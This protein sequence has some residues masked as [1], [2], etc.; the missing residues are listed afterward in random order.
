MKNCKAITAAFLLVILTALSAF[1]KLD[2]DV[3]KKVAEQL[4]KWV[5]DNPQEKVYL[6]FDKP[7]YAVGDDIWF[8][9]YVTAGPKH[10]LS[11]LSGILNV[12][13]ITDRD[14]IK[15]AIKIPLSAGLG[16]GDFKL[17]DSL[18]EGN[19]RIRAY[20]NYMR[21]A[22]DDYFFD[23]I[24]HIGNSVNNAVFT[25]ANYLYS[26][27]K[28]QQKVAATLNYLD[29]DGKA[30]AGK[31]VTYEVQ[32]DTKT[33][34]RGK[35]IT[36]NNGNLNL[37]FANNTPNLLKNGR[38]VTNIK[39]DTKRSPIT[40]TFPVKATSAKVDVQFFPES[41]YLVNGVRCKVAFKALGADGLG[42]DVKGTIVDEIGNEVIK[43]TT[44]HLGMGNFV[45]IPEGNK[46]YTCNI[47]YPDGSTGAISLPAANEKGY[48]LSVYNND[49]DYVTVKISLNEATLRDNP[50][51]EINLVAQAGG[52][53]V[54]AAKTK[55][56]TLAFSTKIPKGRF[57][58]GIVQFALFSSKGEA[59]N[60]RIILIQN[61]D[62]LNIS[63]NT[64]KQSYALREKVKLNIDAKNKD[65]QPVV[66]AY[67]VSVIDETKVQVDESSET[68]ILSGI[69]LTSDIKGYIEKPN[70]YFT[71]VN[72]KTKADLDI[73]MLTQGYRRFTWKQ[74]MADQFPPMAFQPE[75]TLDISGHLKTLSGK[76]VPNGK[77]SLF[78]T[79]GGL[80]FLDTLTDDKGNFTFKNLIFTDSAKF[81]VQA[82][83]AKD[84]KN[85]QIDLDN[86]SPQAISKNKN[87][88]DIEVNI[89][90]VMTSYLQNSKKQYDDFLKYGLITRTNLMKE[91]SI[92][93]KKQPAVKHSDNLNGAGN[94]DQIIKTD[95]LNSCAT[96]TDC[97]LMQIHFVNF[98]N[99]MAYSTRS[100]GRPMLI[101]LDGMQ[102]SAD[103]SLDDIPAT[104]VA[105]VEVL[106]SI[107]YTGL[108][109]GQGGA[110][111]LVVTT[112][113]GDEVTSYQRYSPGIITYSPLGYYRARQFYSPQYDDPKTNAK[114][115]DL[116][117]TIF[118][119]GNFFTDKT[120]VTSVSFFNAD[121][122]G[123]YRAVIEGIDNDGNIGRAVYRYKVE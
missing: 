38:I 69:L 15:K 89:N 12:E 121:T 31:E 74:L 13:L 47:T 11:A 65:N 46:K 90:N 112:K 36:D 84:R 122:K 96:L 123:T 1:F 98:R 91:V 50:G 19:Y 115:A 71:G 24:I 4:N 79:S 27:E 26:T 35:G 21:N 63:L 30:Y 101:V 72:D 18:R 45:M 100:P 108:Y 22:S 32:L 20:T 88:P 37:N 61:P 51:G 52:T 111:V 39:L 107:A 10:Q 104:D 40:K 70:Y 86:I 42:V 117:T 28:N 34:S 17:T 120:G 95:Q 103:F 58:S 60:E 57:P 25:K 41:G 53:I 118:W 5:T 62:L 67:S 113:R 82:R 64:A 23:K 2:D 68:T 49:P 76:P 94:A 3:I 93:E 55:V 99:G 33:V 80:F 81:V 92:T 54:Y 109:G 119:K 87:S 48:V 78:S 14:S 105:S 77:V 106:R 75:R 116:R 102:M 56:E 85:V 66:G 73:L 97:L 16:W 29:F 114:V 6:H 83:T 8:K 110:G 44:Q 9:A 59:L 43:I 7:Y